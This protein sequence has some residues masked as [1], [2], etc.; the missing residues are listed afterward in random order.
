MW[1]SISVQCQKCG[2]VSDALI[3]TNTKEFELYPKCQ[4]VDTFHDQIITAPTIIS[5]GNEGTAREG[6]GKGY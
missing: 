5:P 1:R 6:R 4:C 3:D 2:M